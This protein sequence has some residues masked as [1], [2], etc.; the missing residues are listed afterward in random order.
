LH[1]EF[2]ARK[3]EFAAWINDHG[4]EVTWNYSGDPRCLYDRTIAL[5][6]SAAE[7]AQAFLREFAE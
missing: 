1:S 5:A 4:L 7:E 3:H 2:K 6:F